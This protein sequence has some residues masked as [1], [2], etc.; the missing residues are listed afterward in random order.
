MSMFDKSISEEKRK[1]LEFAE[2]A[3][4]SEWKYPSFA[5]RLFHGLPDWDLILPFPQQSLEDKKEGDVFIAKLEKVLREKLNPDEV[6][7]TCIIPDEVV[8]A[9]GEIGAFAIKIPKE[10]GG[11]GLG[12]VN[13]NRAIHLVASYCG[14]TA[15]LLSAHQSIGVPQPLKLFGTDEQ[16]KKYLPMFANGTVSAFALTEPEAGSDPRNMTTTATPVEDGK[17]FV[18]NGEKLWCTNG[19]IAGVLVVMA[20]TPPKIVHGKERKQIT[21]FIVETNTPGVEVVHRCQFMGL[22]GIQNGLMRFRD[23]KVPKE[24]IILGEGEGLKLALMTLNTGRLTLPAAST[25]VGKWC[26]HVA[27]KWSAQRV[28]WGTRIGDHEAVALKLGYIASHTFAMDAI[29]WLTSSMADDK[30]K[31]IRLEA[32]IAKYFCTEHAWKIVNETLQIRGGQGYETS[33]SLR[34]RGM[35]GWPV[36]RVLRD[37]RINMIIEGTSEIMHLF[38]AREAIDPHLSRAKPLLSPR[39][40]LGA[41]ISTALSLLKYY[42]FWY[43]RMWMPSF[44]SGKPGALPEPLRGHMAYV[45]R[46]SKRLARHTF[47]KMAKYQQKLEAKQGVLNRIVDIGTDLLVMAACCSYAD[48]LAQKGQANAVDLADAFCRDAR[49]RIEAAFHDNQSNHDRLHAGNARK[50]LAGDYVWLENDII[51]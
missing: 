48:S 17:Y 51:V 25:G 22:H 28:Q 30:K 23:V 2:D 21:A 50:L 13:Y 34:A 32:A 33:D 38:I 47:H 35:I 37:I 1:S 26:L 44:L 36:E 7:R 11:L 40:P 24:N 43:P 15:V 6:D 5:L 3:R 42:A 31:D 14:S 20:V 29:S 45:Q 46:A 9:L 8:K 16:K 4:E 27:R 19:L 12:Q 39:T 49:T 41:K 10:Y 18:L